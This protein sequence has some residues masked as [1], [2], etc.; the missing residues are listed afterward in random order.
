VLGV[1]PRAFVVVSGLERRRA[2]RKKR[3]KGEVPADDARWRT[4]TVV[5]VGVTAQG[6]TPNRFV[7]SF[8]FVHHHG[9]I[10]HIIHVFIK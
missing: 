8:S 7:C 9:I 1:A 4:P 10:H 6:S 2:A 3:A 5:M